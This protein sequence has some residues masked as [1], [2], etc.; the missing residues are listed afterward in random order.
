MTIILNETETLCLIKYVFYFLLVCYT[1][2]KPLCRESHG[3]E[4]QKEDT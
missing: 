4:V 2:R 3:K 1:T